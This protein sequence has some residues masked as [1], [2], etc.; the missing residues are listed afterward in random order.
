MTKM[1]SPID[2]G[3]AAKIMMAALFYDLD[4]DGR[5]EDGGAPDEL[6]ER[7]ALPEPSSPYGLAA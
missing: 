3:L 4:L 1:T 7:P 6:V 5:V 2:D